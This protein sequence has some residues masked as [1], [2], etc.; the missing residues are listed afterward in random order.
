MSSVVAAFGGDAG[1]LDDSYYKVS[2]LSR[3]FSLK[4]AVFWR[5][6]VSAATNCYGRFWLVGSLLVRAHGIWCL[7]RLHCRLLFLCHLDVMQELSSSHPRGLV[8]L[9]SFLCT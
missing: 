8:N 6:G 5:S 7:L 2:Q 4:R 3:F 1:L 9:V